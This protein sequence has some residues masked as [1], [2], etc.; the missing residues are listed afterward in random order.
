MRVAVLGAG[1]LGARAARQ[2]LSLGEVDHLLVVDRNQAQAR[3][4][5]GSL[6]KVA[7]TAPAGEVDFD[8]ADAVIIAHPDP[9][10]PARQALR[11]G[12]HVIVASPLLEHARDLVPL[13]SEAAERGLTV[14]VGAGFSPGLT[15]ILTAYAARRLERVTS[16]SIASAGVGGPACAAERRAALTGKSLRWDGAWRTERAGAGR[17]LAAFPEP[18]GSLDCF[19]A[20]TADAFLLAAAFPAARIDAVVAATAGERVRAR[21]PVPAR[22]RNEGGLGALRVEVHGRNH[23]GESEVYVLGAIDRPA[24]AAGAVAANVAR[25]AIEGRLQARAGGLARVVPDPAGFLRDLAGL[26][27][28]AAEFAGVG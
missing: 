16:V 21:L 4:V 12:A 10:T 19:A 11:S 20:A 22:D 24:M 8:G 18:V 28:R 9:V 7:T 14:A 25:W 3:A 23:V 6:G 1:A 26:G 17:R 15:C 13:D 5:A 27:V 2:L